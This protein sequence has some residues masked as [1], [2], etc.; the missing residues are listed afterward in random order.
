MHG[1]IFAMTRNCA[2]PFCRGKGGA[3]PPVPICR[4][5]RPANAIRIP[6]NFPDITQ[7][8]KVFKPIIAAL[9]SHVVGYGMWIALDADFRIATDDVT[10]WLPEP[11]WGIATIPA[12]W[13][14]KIMPW[15]IAS[16]L[17]LFA[18]R[19]SAQRAFDVGM[20][21]K[22]V[23]A[24]QL[25]AV[26]GMKELMVRAS[27]LDYTAVDQITDY[28]QTRVMNSEDRKEGGRAFAERRVVD[29]PDS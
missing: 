8:Q 25:M 16:E 23:P 3:S 9:H 7:P 10:F 19:V 28:V 1:P 6:A 15:A 26:Q 4:A 21:N 20:I 13:F 18:E 12:A 14:P 22:I 24:D 5:G 11:Q 2:S 27:A 29:W 17:L